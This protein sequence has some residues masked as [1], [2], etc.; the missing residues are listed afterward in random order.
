MTRTRDDGAG[1]AGMRPGPPAHAAAIPPAMV[2]A[3]KNMAESMELSVKERFRA[4]EALNAYAQKA[5]A[6]PAYAHAAAMIAHQL[7]E[8]PR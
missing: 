4:A 7:R 2:E 8:M 1:E 3:V 6:D 5:D